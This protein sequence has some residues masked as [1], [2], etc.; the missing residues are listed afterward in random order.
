MTSKKPKQPKPQSIRITRDAFDFIAHAARNTDPDEFVGMLRQNR[1]GIIDTILI[2]PLSEYG[3]G[4]SSINLNMVPALS[5]SCGSIHSHP[6]APPLPSQ[7]D[8]LFF[9]RMGG[10]HLI[11]ASPYDDRS[12]RGYDDA[13]APLGVEIV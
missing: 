3:S 11:I 13:G 8:R 10:V 5:D 1:R 7:A 9:S 4:F 12:I 2:I 6:G